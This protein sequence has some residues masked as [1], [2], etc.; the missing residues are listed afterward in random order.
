[1]LDKVLRRIT[2]SLL[3][4]YK[5]RSYFLNR[6]G[7]DI[8]DSAHIK[9]GCYF[10]GGH[11][12]VGD[13]VFINHDCCFYSYPDETSMIEIEENVTVAMHVTF[14]THTHNMGTA[15]CRAIRSTITAPILVEKGSWIGSDVTILPGMNIGKG[16]IIAAGS[17]VIKGWLDNSLYA[18]VPA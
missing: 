13:N 8:S 16:C 6:G 7:Y 9:S 10:E 4:P 17:V 1:M 5:L 3:C 12:H 11:V 14:C 15:E 18:G 2:Q